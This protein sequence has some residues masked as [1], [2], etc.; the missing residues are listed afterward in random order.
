[1][2]S[3]ETSKRTVGNVENCEDILDLQKVFDVQKQFNDVW[4]VLESQ[5]K[6]VKS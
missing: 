5:D 6:F 1:M 2:E 3:E 4:E